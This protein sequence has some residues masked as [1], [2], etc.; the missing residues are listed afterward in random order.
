[1]NSTL[2]SLYFVPQFR[3]YFATQPKVTSMGLVS[4][5]RAFV[6]QYAESRVSRSL[7]SDILDHSPKFSR[8]SQESA[9]LFMLS[10]LQT[11]D[12]EMGVDGASSSAVV[13]SWQDKLRRCL[14]SGCKPLREVF[15]VVIEEKR[16]CTSC[17]TVNSKYIYQRSL[18]LNLAPSRKQGDISFNSCLEKFLAPKRDSENALHRC[19]YCQRD[20][21][22][23]VR[24]VLRHIGSALI[25]NLQRFH[26]HSPETKVKMPSKLDMSTILGEHGSYS[27]CSAINHIGSS[28]SG[29]HYTCWA[30]SQGRWVYLNDEHATFDEITPN[31][32]G[33]CTIFIYVKDT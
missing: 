9:Y 26:Y 11:I 16:G 5:L 27:I 14:A 15:S 19:D 23:E 7:L 4:N 17:G 8:G 20:R 18:S 3:C 30:R 6:S 33:S 29:G 12:E 24:K 31:Q 21:V 13:S 2:N 32:L 28:A 1:M 22:H 10:I 25:I